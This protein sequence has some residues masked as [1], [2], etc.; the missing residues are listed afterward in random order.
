MRDKEE[1]TT[2][3][4]ASFDGAGFR[5]FGSK[6]FQSFRPDLLFVETFEG[7]GELV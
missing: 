1:Y 7:V 5:L 2:T 3:I 6:R 4:C